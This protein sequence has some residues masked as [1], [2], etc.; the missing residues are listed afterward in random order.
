MKIENRYNSLFFKFKHLVQKKHPFFLDA[1]IIP[2]GRRLK[3]ALTRKKA[4]QHLY[5]LLAVSPYPPITAV[6]IETFN[7]CNNNCS[8]CPVNKTVDTRIPKLMPEEIFEKIL[9]HLE[10]MNYQGT[11][12]MNS[13]N[14]PF[15]DSRIARFWKKISERLPGATINIM[16]NG[17]VLTVEKLEAVLPFVHDVTINNY[18][19]LLQLNP[20]TEKIYQH[21]SASPSPNYEKVQIRIRRSNEF[22]STRGGQ[23]K[24]RRK[25]RPLNIS[26]PQPFRSLV[27]RPD[28]KISLCCNDALGTMTLGDLN[29]ESILDVW[30]GPKFK[31]IRKHLIEGNRRN[32]KLCSSCDAYV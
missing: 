11:V 31:K 19:D 22:L 6:E 9:L 23:A 30:Q 13:N 27:I 1:F 24:N 18:N 20:S 28:G 14:E 4:Q 25:I 17:L 29:D 15:L 3:V 32:I 21:I 16:T 8:F 26:C 7:R 12:N 10:Q 5:D 2:A